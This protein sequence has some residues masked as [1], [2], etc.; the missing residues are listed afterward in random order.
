MTVFG[1]GAATVGFLYAAP[2]VGALIGA[3]TSGWVGR[4]KEQGE[5]VVWAVV[6]GGPRVEV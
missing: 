5:A 3:V 6:A 4:V 2:G 1:L